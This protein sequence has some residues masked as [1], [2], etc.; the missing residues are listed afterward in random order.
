M[1]HTSEESGVADPAL[2]VRKRR[3]SATR[4][5]DNVFQASLGLFLHMID[6]AQTAFLEM[7]R[8]PLNSLGARRSL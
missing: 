1:C 5:D 4:D 8:V 2:R 3:A 7:N 6:C